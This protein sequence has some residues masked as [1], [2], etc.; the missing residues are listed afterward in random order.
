[1]KSYRQICRFIRCYVFSRLA[2]GYLRASALA[3][4]IVLVATT[5]VYAAEIVPYT[6]KSVRPAG[7]GFVELLGPGKIE[8]AGKARDF[9]GIKYVAVRNIDSL[10]G[11]A[12]LKT[13]CVIS[14]SSE[15]Y[16]AEISVI[17]Q[18]CRQILA[19]VQIVQ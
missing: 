15:G 6:I 2:P 12:N 17:D 9:I 5:A 18:S 4:S 3:V 8:I 7:V 13:G 10:S 11:A 19:V 16:T 1:M 14:Y